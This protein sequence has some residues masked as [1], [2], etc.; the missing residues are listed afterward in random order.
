LFKP[1]TL[2][3]PDG[4]PPTPGG[5][6]AGRACIRGADCACCRPRGRWPRSGARPTGTWR[7]PA[8]AASTS[9]AVLRERDHR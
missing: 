2:A 9:A 4:T 7:R 8:T 6:R 3:G 1:P 5:A